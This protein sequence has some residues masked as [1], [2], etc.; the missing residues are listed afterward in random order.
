MT[1]FKYRVYPDTNWHLSQETYD[2]RRLKLEENFPSIVWKNDFQ[3]AV[4]IA[5]KWAN[6]TELSIVVET[7]YP[8][9]YNKIYGQ[10]NFAWFIHPFEKGRIQQFKHQPFHTQE[11]K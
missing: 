6:S 3:E 1:K 2:S 10:G 4:A 7:C 8:T 9:H 11:N 5:R